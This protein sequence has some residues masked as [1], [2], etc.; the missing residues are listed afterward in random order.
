MKLKVSLNE[1]VPLGSDSGG[2]AWELHSP[3]TEDDVDRMVLSLK[4]LLRDEHLM[5]ESK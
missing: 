3:F 5:E 1:G 2:L 4:E